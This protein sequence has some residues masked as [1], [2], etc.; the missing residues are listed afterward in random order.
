MLSL[1]NVT[2]QASEDQEISEQKS[3]KEFYYF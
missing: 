2:L 3:V 1:S